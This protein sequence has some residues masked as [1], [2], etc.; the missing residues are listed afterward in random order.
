M[1]DTVYKLVRFQPF[2]GYEILGEFNTEE[3]AEARKAALLE[4]APK[5]ILVIASVPRALAGAGRE[6]DE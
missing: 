1:S 4:R 6:K 3:E 2:D 5:E